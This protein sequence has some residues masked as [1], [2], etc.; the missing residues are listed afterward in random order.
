MRNRPRA[1]PEFENRPE[2]NYG[3]RIG[4]MLYRIARGLQILGL[5]ILPVGVSGNLARPDEITVKTSLLIALAGMAVF[6]LGWLLQQKA[7]R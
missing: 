2:M 3:L 4:I 7:P 5:L 6:G 1:F